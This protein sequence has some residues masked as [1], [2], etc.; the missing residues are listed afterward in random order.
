[1]CLERAD[2]AVFRLRGGAAMKTKILEV[3]DEGTFIA[4]LCV[5]MNPDNDA[6]RYFLRRCGYP[7]DGRPN[8]AITHL[9]ADGDSF[10]NDPHAWGGRTYP[11][12]HKYIIEH[13]AELQDGDVVDVSHILGE[14]PTRK[15]SER[16]SAFAFAAFGE[17]L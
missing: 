15:V 4:M 10:S 11:E 1:M 3:R 2:G 12:A 14:T 13:W 8:I 17:P 9:S 16:V 6:Q 7:C 5:D